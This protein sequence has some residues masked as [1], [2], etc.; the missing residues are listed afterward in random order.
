MKYLLD[1]HVLLW[2]FL[3]TGKLSAEI[4]SVLLDEYNDV[5]YSPISL[6]E[7][8]IKYSLKKLSLSGGTPEDFFG[9][10]EDSFLVC[11]AINN[12]DLVSVYRLPAH[13][14]DPFDRLLIWQA[15]R[16]NFVLL[17]ADNSMESYKKDGLK[18]LL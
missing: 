8:S 1:T 6:W 18:V 17:S 5:H 13:H 9:V 2:S 16:N 15:I 3:D 7:I 10:L 12:D 4:K 14:K 11:A